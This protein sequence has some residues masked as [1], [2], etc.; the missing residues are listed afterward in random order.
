MLVVFDENM[1]LIRYSAPFKFGETCIEYS[2]SV[3]VEDERVLIN[4]SEWDRTT[5]IGVYDKKY[6][7]SLLIFKPEKV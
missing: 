7:E 6:I 3:V 1:H 4:Y 5:K 2:L